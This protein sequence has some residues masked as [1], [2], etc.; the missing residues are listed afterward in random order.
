MCVCRV[1]ALTEVLSVCTSAPNI[2]KVDQIDYIATQTIDRLRRGK[3]FAFGVDVQLLERSSP[4][5]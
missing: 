2:G 5:V 3:K 4:P 1:D